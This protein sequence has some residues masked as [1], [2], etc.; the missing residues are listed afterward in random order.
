MLR[1]KAEM[2]WKDVKN[3][4]SIIQVCESSLQNGTGALLKIR[5][6]RNELAGVLATLPISMF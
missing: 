2:F 6:R 1:N 5:P 3:L 4:Y